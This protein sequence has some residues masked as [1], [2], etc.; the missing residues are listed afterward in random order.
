MRLYA[1]ADIHGRP[2]H[3]DA[4]DRAADRFSPDLVV[5]AG[6]LTHFFNWRACL[7]RL[8]RLPVTILAIRGN[9]DLNRVE[10][11]ITRAGNMSLLTP[12]PTRAGG[13]S[14]V[15]TGGT[16][17]LPFASRICLQEQKRLNTLPCPMEMDTVLVVH[18]PPKGVCDKVGGRFSSGSK[19]LMRFIRHAG[20]GLVLCG[21]IHEQPGSATVGQTTVVNC[22]MSHSS[23][24]AVVDLEKG[25]PP[26]VNL[27]HPDTLR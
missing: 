2:G 17:V 26:R 23:V 8:A 15:G 1:V 19:G 18:P 11:G 4:I 12:A 25:A 13:F 10:S 22:S 7:A 20:P 14:F 24:G 6:D 9:T 21:H 5:V 27:L 16:L 3:L